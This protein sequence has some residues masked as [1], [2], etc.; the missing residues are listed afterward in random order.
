MIS[1]ESFGIVAAVLI[2]ILRL[3]VSIV[4]KFQ[5]YRL[6]LIALVTFEAA[7]L[8][9]LYIFIHWSMDG[10]RLIRMRNAGDT[11]A[12]MSKKILTEGDFKVSCDVT[13]KKKIW[14]C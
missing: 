1:L 3:Y 13:C 10:V 11:D 4:K 8:L 12:M 2:G 9:A 6:E 14:G 7:V 5:P